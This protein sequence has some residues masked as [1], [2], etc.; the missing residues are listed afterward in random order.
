MIKKI[1][2]KVSRR[3]HHIFETYL[4][5]SWQFLDLDLCILSHSIDDNDVYKTQI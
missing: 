4:H 2:I 3:L 1:F 5:F